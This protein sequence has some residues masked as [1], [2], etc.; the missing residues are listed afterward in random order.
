MEIH[1]QVEIHFIWCSYIS[2]GEGSLYSL[3]CLQTR[4]NIFVLFSPLQLSSSVAVSQVPKLDKLGRWGHLISW[5]G[6]THFLVQ[7]LSQFRRQLL[8][9][10]GMGILLT[11]VGDATKQGILFK[12]KHSI[13]FKMGSN[14]TL[15][16]HET[17]A[18][19][20]SEKIIDHDTPD[21]D[22]ANT[23]KKISSALF[24]WAVQHTLI[25][26]V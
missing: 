1:Y 4:G 14:I 12:Q 11:Q 7:A 25:V 17:S 21:K 24:S 23:S 26:F 9:S 2:L 18:E 8:V 20:F 5:E 16:F 22:F 10:V 13:N 19:K 3:F 15:T 6:L